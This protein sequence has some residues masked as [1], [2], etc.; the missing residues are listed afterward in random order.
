MKI[1]GWWALILGIPIES[2]IGNPHLKFFENYMLVQRFT[3]TG[4]Y[5]ADL[6]GEIGYLIE[7][8]FTLEVLHRF[9]LLMAAGELAGPEDFPYLNLSIIASL[10]DNLGKTPP[11]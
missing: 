7:T 11:P 1:Q 10:A 9:L 5:P 8:L 6:P 2:L 4:A 3:V